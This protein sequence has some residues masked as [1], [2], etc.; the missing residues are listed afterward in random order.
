[1]HH[2]AS[3]ARLLALDA[4][5]IDDGS[6]VSVA[7]YL[8]P[9]DGGGML[10][11]WD[12]SATQPS[13]GGTVLGGGSRGRWLRLHDGCL[14]FRTFGVFDA[15]TPADAALDAMVNDPAVHRVEA[16]TDL[17]FTRR[18]TF[19]R[20]GVELDFGGNTV[21][22]DGIERNTHDN[23]FGAVFLFRGE[24]TEEVVTHKLTAVMPDLSD[25]F[26]VGDSARFEVG[27]WWTAEVDALAGKYERELQRMVQVTQ[28][29]DGSRVRVNYK[30]GWELAA[31]RTITWTRVKPVEKAHVRNLIF[32]APG[33]DQ[34]TGS[35]PVAYEYAVSCDVEGVHATGTFW[36]V[37]MRRWCTHFRTV[38][39]SLKN[40]PTVM[41]GGAGYLTQQIYCLYG[42]VA[43]C[44]TSN[45][46][47]LNDFTASAYCTVENCH[48]DGDDE[49]GNPF[50][51]HGQYEHDLVFTGCSGLMDLAN[52]GA[53][54]GTSAKRITV[55]KHL[56]SWFVAGTKI[57]D[58]T[59]EDVRV[60]PRSTFDPGGT[61]QV[62]ADGVQL[63]GCVA[64]TFA[65]GQR[66]NRSGRPNLVQ[67]CSFD[68]PK[69]QVVVQTPVSNP[70]HFVDC[71]FTGVDGA[72]FRGSGPLR[73]TACR[74]DGA[75][76][77]L[78]ASEITFS[79]GL[80]DN[81]TIELSAVRDQV[82]RLDGTT[83]RKAPL[84]RAA[85]PGRLAWE[86]DGCRV[87]GGGLELTTGENRYAAT[88]TSFTGGRLTLTA[89]SSLLH[90]GCVED[91]VARSLPSSSSVL[92]ADTLEVAHGTS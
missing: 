10:V 84:T 82:L 87:E 29:L 35:H 90:T 56:C 88:G 23:P 65:I 70:V 4:R 64:R 25:V 72:H 9:G 67:G 19:S 49:G 60:I 33:G 80:V 36:P 34:Y 8:A 66:S 30:N 89:V 71:S 79:G 15:E 6:L 68:L 32:D 61:L 43:D 3:V 47:H 22:T 74:L 78:G 1:M 44:V 59:L 42:H 52:S 46:R 24:V 76:A 37:I 48:G 40:P 12:A 92:I 86:L 58:L 20:S 39:C 5:T 27:Q 50:T 55:R 18:H 31:G 28:I 41:Y 14:D 2:V 75:S 81:V 51:T 16:H 11:R 38:G 83:L 54:W 62:N 69:G 57:T 13:N 85:G 26:E 45:V 7:G 21:R 53:L 17:L 77:T 91:G 63:R 73:F